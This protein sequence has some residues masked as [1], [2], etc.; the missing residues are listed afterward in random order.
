MPHTNK[1]TKPTL[2]R[3]FWIGYT[4]I[5]TDVFTNASLCTVTRS[6]PGGDVPD[7]WAADEIILIRTG[8]TQQNLQQ[9]YWLPCQTAFDNFK[10]ATAT[11]R[12]HCVPLAETQ[13]D[14]E[15]LTMMKPKRS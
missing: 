13:A 6:A 1:L 7:D 12:G 2:G 10:P 11:R 14:V 15:H 4:T 5:A 9:L 8:F 3:A